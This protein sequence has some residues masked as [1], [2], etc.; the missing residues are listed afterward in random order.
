MWFLNSLRVTIQVGLVREESW[1]G[2]FDNKTYDIHV[3]NHQ[4]YIL[5]N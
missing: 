3:W 2:R 1:E 5:Q 4:K